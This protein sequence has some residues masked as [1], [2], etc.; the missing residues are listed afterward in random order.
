MFQSE[1][2]A[3]SLVDTLKCEPKHNCYKEPKVLI[4]SFWEAIQRG[5]AT[6]RLPKPQQRVIVAWCVQIPVLGF[7]S[8]RY[9]QKLVRQYFVMEI[10]EGSDVTVAEKQ[11]KVMFLTAPKFKF[12]DICNYLAEGKSY[13]D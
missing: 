2:V 5:G 1:H 9:D 6:F 8:G 7:N 12:L 11:G 4:Q 3:V 10:L 13:K